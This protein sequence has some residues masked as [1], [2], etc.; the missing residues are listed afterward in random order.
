MRFLNVSFLCFSNLLRNVTWRS[1]DT[2]R[3]SQ[4]WVAVLLSCLVQGALHATERVTNAVKCAPGT[5]KCGMYFFLPVN[6]S[7]RLVA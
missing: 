5:V 2:F 1:T 7:Y 4:C 6:E 3:V